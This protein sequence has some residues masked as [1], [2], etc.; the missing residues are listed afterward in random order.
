MELYNETSSTSQ[1]LE[2]NT[3]NK[4]DMM[5]GVLAIAVFSLV[6]IYVAAVPTLK[7]PTGKVVKCESFDRKLKQCNVN[8]NVHDVR[9]LIQHSKSACIKGQT[10]FAGPRY[11]QVAKGCR[12]TFK[13]EGSTTEKPSSFTILKSCSSID[14]KPSTCRLFKDAPPFIP[15]IKSIDIVKKESKSPC[16]FDTSFFALNGK[17]RAV[18]VIDG[19]RALFAV[20]FG[21]VCT[22]SPDKAVLITNV[23]YDPTN[24]VFSPDARATAQTVHLWSS[25]ESPFEQEFGTVTSAVST[26]QSTTFSIE[27]S[28]TLS[29]EISRTIEVS[30]GLPKFG[31]SASNT[32]TLGAERTVTASEGGEESVTQEI[33]IESPQIKVPPHSN[34]A[35]RFEASMLT[36]SVPFTAEVVI[37]NGCTNRTEEVI[38][39]ATVKG[40]VS[41][42]NIKQQVGPATP[43]ECMNPEDP[44]APKTFSEFSSFNWCEPIDQKCNTNPICKRFGAFSDADT[45][46]PANNGRLFT[47]CAIAKAH[48]SCLGIVPDNTMVCPSLSGKF[49]PCCEQGSTGQKASASRQLNSKSRRT[50]KSNKSATSSI[51]SKPRV[52]SLK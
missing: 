10:F 14:F 18:R 39:K 4:L 22:V 28:T 11:I 37:T 43:V 46:C 5:R 52:I 45:C 6:L 3:A 27:R 2:R 21:E 29:V 12:A 25:N 20:N 24:V 8:F 33:S 15:P 19:C 23:K 34:L 40:I 30:A 1:Y 9:K 16:T 32:L 50:D 38:G 49:H 36:A 48:T 26:S 35:A 51:P 17:D 7:N 42:G 13:V 47:C 41:S 31:A 44:R